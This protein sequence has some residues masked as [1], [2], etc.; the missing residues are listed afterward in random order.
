VAGTTRNNGEKLWL[1]VLFSMLLR[2]VRDGG[3]VFV[4]AVLVRSIERTGYHPREP[5]PGPL[6]PLLVRTSSSI[7][8]RPDQLDPPLKISSNDTY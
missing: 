5:T 8:T 1:Y 3:C 2:R 4:V 6:V 7:H